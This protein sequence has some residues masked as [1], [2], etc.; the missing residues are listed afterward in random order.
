MS[1]SLSGILYRKFQTETKGNDFRTR[2]FVLY[3]PGQ[4]PEHIKFQLVQNNVELIDNIA[5]N[6]TVNV[7]FD[8]KGRK[9]EK[10]GKEQFF[11]SLNAWKIVVENMT[12]A[13]PVTN[14]PEDAEVID[15][16]TPTPF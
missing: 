14:D 7:T 4:Y 8:V 3:I 13:K 15:F 2:E 12:G 10:D 5:E 6:W 11:N 1:F 9:Y 16:D